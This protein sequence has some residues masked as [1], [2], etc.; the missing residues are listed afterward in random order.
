MH[1]IGKFG[2]KTWSLEKVTLYPQNYIHLTLLT[3]HVINCI[4]NIYNLI[5]SHSNKFKNIMYFMGK[6]SCIILYYIIYIMKKM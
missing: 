4:D 1:Q 2:L 6:T 5:R 3:S